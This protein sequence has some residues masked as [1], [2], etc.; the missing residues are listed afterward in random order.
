MSKKD[1][2]E[3][4]S[5]ILGIDKKYKDDFGIT[6]RLSVKDIPELL[7]L[8]GINAKT[9]DEIESSIDTLECCLCTHIIPEVK[10]LKENESILEITVSSSE[11]E[12]TY[13]WNLEQESGYVDSGK[14]IAANLNKTEIIHNNSCGNHAKLEFDLPINLEI[15]YHKLTISDKQ[16]KNYH[17]KLIVVPNKCYTPKLPKNR[18]IFGPK[19]YLSNMNLSN[20]YGAQSIKSLKSFIKKNSDNGANIIGIGTVNLT[21]VDENGKYNPYRPSDRMFLNTFFLD[22]DE[23]AEF[24]EDATVS[25]KFLSQE[26]QQTLEETAKNYE[27]DYKSIF[28]MKF[29]KY[30]LLYESFRENHI[31]KNTEKF[32]QFKTF[33]NEQGN[34]LHKL[35]LFRALQDFLSSEQEKYAN[36]R[37]WPDAYKDTSS[38]VVSQFERHNQEL[39][40]LYKFLQWQAFIQFEQAGQT[41]YNQHLDIGLYADLSFCVDPNGS[42]TWIY[43]DY[44]IDNSKIEIYSKDKTQKYCCAALIPSKLKSSGYAYLVDILR[45]NMLHYGA[46]NLLNLEYL[47][48]PALEIPSGNTSKKIRIKYPVKDIL[49]VIALESNKNKCMVT[50]DLSVFEDEDKKLLN[51]YGIYDEKIFSL[52]QITNK[53]ELESFYKKINTFYEKNNEKIQKV[54]E[55]IDKIPTSTYRIQFNSKFTYNQAREMI[56]YFK[57]LGISHIYSS[58]IL[59]TRPNSMHGYDIVDHKKINQECGTYEEFELFSDALHENNMGLIIDVVPNHMAIGKYNKLWMDVLENGPSSEFSHYFDIDW[60]PIKKE[61]TGKILIP[62]LGD[63]YGNVLINGNIVFSIDLDAGKLYANYYEHEFPLNPSTY[64]LI[65]EH[66]IEV[67]Q[68]RLG[69][70]NNDYLEYLSIITVFKN[71]PHYLTKNFEEIK[72][73]IR[74]KNIAFRRLSD[75]CKRNHIIKGFIEENLIDYKCSPEDNITIDRVHNLLNQ[76]PYRLAFWRVSADEINYRRFFDIND[77]AAVCVEKPDVFSNTLSLIFQLIERKKIDGLR[78]DHPDGLLK[79]AEF[80]K[81][82]QYEISKKINIDFDTSEEKLLGSDKLPFYIIAEKILAGDEKLEK[83]WAINGTVGYE[84]LNSVNRL[85]INAKYENEFTNFYKSF[86]KESLNYSSMVIEC[87]KLIMNSSFSGELNVLSNYLSQISEMYLLSRDYTL[88]SLRNALVEIISWFN[89]YRTYISEDEEITEFNQ[90]HI[91]A[92]IELSKRHSLTTDVSI[93]D[94]IKEILL[95]EMEEDKESDKYKQILNF[96]LKFQQYTGPLMAKSFE[97]T[98]FYRYN[99]LISLNEVG[100]EP[101]SFGISIDEFHKQNINRLKQTPHNMLSTS[102]HD[103]KR[104]EDV[105]CRI[106]AISEFPNEWTKLI[107]RLHN[108]NKSKNSVSIDKNTEYLIYQSLIGIFP[109]SGISKESITDIESRLTSYVLKAAREAKTYTSWV[110][111]NEEYEKTLAIFINQ[112]LGFNS[113]HIFWKNLLPFINMITNIGYLNSISQAVLKLTC[114]GIPDIYQGNELNSLSL[115][116]PDNRRPVDYNERKEKIEKIQSLIGS[117]N[118]E[119]FKNSVE[120]ILYPVSDGNLK[121]L[122]TTTLLNFRNQEVKLFGEGEYTPIKI[123]SKNEDNFISYIRKHENKAIIVVVPRLY[124]EILNNELSTEIRSKIF[125]ESFINLPEEFTNY[126]WT[127]IIT[128]NELIKNTHKIYLKQVKEDNLPIIL[129]KGKKF[130]KKTNK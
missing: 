117:V 84:F 60:T 61:L 86:I 45:P 122:Y 48:N 106:N 24:I 58:P 36:W 66:R 118:E 63:Y 130:S 103:T 26:F 31:N 104:S 1:L 47:L 19:I 67:L 46:I 123:N 88:N 107:K 115:V 105:R 59:S 56:P 4:L 129:L 116:D 78:I 109:P 37:E 18:Q 98:L 82:L 64:P 110:N 95:L 72:E 41:S 124:R 101:D 127:S 85:F 7:R 49:G 25:L 40:D 9:K 73:R 2:L 91:N 80:Y 99:R 96:S 108:I 79:P 94:F 3:K 126:S 55:G 23:I 77:L 97:D 65:L 32:I 10:V 119:N 125:E 121:L 39:I 15:G 62:V 128:K 6:H 38:E 54:N 21:V 11:L 34:K 81:K 52:T 17:C 114:P 12:S 44:F 43:N 28:D 57:S 70:E 75:L 20:I 68:A 112:L 53:E 42:E 5:Y 27:T 111:V 113:K 8:Y 50:A 14:F 92:A 33:I 30:K 90:V 120:K 51:E 87:K 93:F 100:S 35:A 89:I 22:I 13:T 29:K 16:G 74:E 69:R 76:Q 71:L 83:N 102:T